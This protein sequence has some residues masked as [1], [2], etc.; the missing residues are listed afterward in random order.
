MISVP[1][2][3]SRMPYQI[4]ITSGYNMLDVSVYPVPPM[5]VLPEDNFFMQCEGRA[6]VTDLK[7]G[8]I[9][10]GLGRTLHSIDLNEIWGGC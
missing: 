7:L 6:G 2:Y 1:K 4:D 5:L 8:G 10:I 3:S 9:M